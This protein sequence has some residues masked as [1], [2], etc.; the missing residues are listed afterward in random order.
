MEV[1]NP[2][3]SDLVDLFLKERFPYWKFKCDG[4]NP[5]SACNILRDEHGWVMLI[6]YDDA[7]RLGDDR[8]AVWAADPTFFEQVAGF[9]LERK[10]E[11]NKSL[12]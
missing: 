12:R 1:K 5:I 2:N 10:R 9:I 7:V 3:L 4:Y 11:I 6:V 8:R